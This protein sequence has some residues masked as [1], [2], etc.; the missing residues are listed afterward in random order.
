[1][2][3]TYAVLRMQESLQI[4]DTSL[5]FDIGRCA[6]IV[7]FSNTV[8]SEHDFDSPFIIMFLSS[9]SFTRWKVSIAGRER[10][11]VFTSWLLLIDSDFTDWA[12]N[13]ADHTWMYT[14]MKTYHTASVFMVH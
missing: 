9:T 2:G 7:F 4:S 10:D 8:G 1:M 12:F 5:L 14:D 3:V 6:V 13:Y 11:N